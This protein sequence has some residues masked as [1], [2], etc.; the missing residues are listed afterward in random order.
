MSCGGG[1]GG[2][3]HGVTC[4]GGDRGHCQGP[5][6]SPRVP[7]PQV[8]LGATVFGFLGDA[9]EGAEAVDVPGDR[10]GHGDGGAR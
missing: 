10:G 4:E 3:G 8:G 7:L 6:R 9:F 2:H 1:G 5:W